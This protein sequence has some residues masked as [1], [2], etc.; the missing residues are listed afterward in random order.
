MNKNLTE[1]AFILDM[2]GSMSHLTSDTIGGYN[3]LIQKQREEVGDANITTVLFD[4]RY[5]LLH[6]RQDIKKVADLTTK[7]YAPL[8][9]TALL[10]A[11]GKTINHIGQE[12]NKTAEEERPAKVIVTIITDGYENASKEY[13]YEKIKE[14]ISHQKEKYSWIFM[15]IGAN[16]DTMKVSGDLGIDAALSA[17]YTYSAQGTSSVYSSLTKSMSYVRS[18]DTDDAMNLCD[19]V[20]NFMSEIE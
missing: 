15:F 17:S 9:C 2:S 19:N 1:M 10:D 20:T 11:I 18:V 16:I 3:S 7:E 8:G 13:T 5:I 4:D 6:D 12:L 14:M